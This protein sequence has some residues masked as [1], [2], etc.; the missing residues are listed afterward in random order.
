MVGR[1]QQARDSGRQAGAS[2]H[3]AAPQ[4]GGAWLA[5]TLL[6]SCCAAH[7]ASAAPDCAAGDP[8]L[9]LLEA[10]TM[11]VAV[12]TA[13]RP[14][15]SPGA[16]YLPEV[17]ASLQTDWGGFVRAGGTGHLVVLVYDTASR[18]G[19]PR[20][21]FRRNHGAFNKL[22]R[23]G[24]VQRLLAGGA[25]M[26][27]VFLTAAQVGCTVHGEVRAAE[28]AAAAAAGSSWLPSWLVGASSADTS[29][30][31]ANDAI[32]PT[33]TAAA[34]AADAAGTWIPRTPPFQGTELAPQKQRQTMDYAFLLLAIA[35]TLMAARNG[36]PLL[37][38]ED[39]NTACP[40]LFA[41]LQEARSAVVV[42]NWRSQVTEQPMVG[43]LS[44]S[45]G[46]LLESVESG[47]KT[48][49]HVGVISGDDNLNRD[50]SDKDSC[51]G[52]IK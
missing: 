39:D 41:F 23:K 22:A 15:L 2:R 17:L 49:T 1:E 30:P 44:A 37:L 6:A 42:R 18:E 50:N 31:F 10:A 3:P 45:G 43:G 25:P 46:K 14:H 13:P 51:F 4:R 24:A 34:A 52:F 36:A 11:I 27:A 5:S 26:S 38:W 32:C 9:P 7:S 20:N 12:P 29:E 28:A 48:G 35:P 19:G 47:A 33:G 8:L 16:H 40:G 21:T